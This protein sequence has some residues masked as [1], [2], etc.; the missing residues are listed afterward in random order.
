MSQISQLPTAADFDTSSLFGIDNPDP[1]SSGDYLTRKV[2][3]AAVADYIANGLDYTTD[4]DT[5]NKKLSG[6]INEVNA[7]AMNMADVYDPTTTSA[8]KYEKGD[9]CIKDNTLYKCTAQNGTYG[10]WDST[11]W[12]ATS[13]AKEISAKEDNL[14]KG[15]LSSGD[16]L[17][18]I[19]TSGFYW[20]VAGVL[21]RP[22]S[23]YGVLEVCKVSSSIYLQRYT[24]SS[25][26]TEDGSV[27]QRQHTSTGWKNWV[28]I[29]V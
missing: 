15:T 1:N 12:T 19:S 20:S 24:V 4:L 5:A 18:N 16:D 28:K 26:G 23:Q 22:I 9:L 6:S 3:A 25:S 14:S 7:K 10:A 8:N 17:D 13:I 2:S 21:N 11:A 27:Y 29:S